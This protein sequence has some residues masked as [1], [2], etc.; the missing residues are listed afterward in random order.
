MLDRGSP[1]SS[2]EVPSATVGRIFR[3]VC[4]VDAHKGAFAISRLI[5]Q[6]GVKLRSYELT[7]RDDPRALAKLIAALDSMLSL[8]ERQQLARVLREPA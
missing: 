2:H 4:W 7:T 8:E 6:T 1:D 3:L 5:L